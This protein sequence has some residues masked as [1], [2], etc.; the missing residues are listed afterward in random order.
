[1]IGKCFSIRTGFA[2][3]E[4]LLAT[5]I[6]GIALIALGIAAGQCVSGI[7]AARAMDGALE[8]A[9]ENFE[10]W[11]LSVESREEILMKSKR[12]ERMLRHRRYLWNW[13]VEATQDSKILRITMSL[14]WM[15]RGLEKE[16][17]F[18]RLARRP[19]EMFP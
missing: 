12:G 5:L 6:L 11:S 9:R 4:I 17:V 19:R 15:E 16:R 1:M 3:L 18:E 7:A 8:I 14:R 10:E 13:N 2:L